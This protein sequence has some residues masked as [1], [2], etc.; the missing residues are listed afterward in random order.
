MKATKTDK[1]ASR[2]RRVRAKVYG[3]SNRPRLSIF[4]SNQHI[5][6]QVIDDTRG[7]TLV[8]ASDIEKET[9]K[10]KGTK[11]EIAKNIGLLVAK[12]AKEKKIKAVVFD[13]GGNLY[14]GRVKAFADGAR[15]GGLE[16]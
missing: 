9:K 2:K 12:R 5:F 6:G 16:F 3:T 13:R 15:E 14:H 11:T 7:I 4:S 10:Q 8:A 1:L